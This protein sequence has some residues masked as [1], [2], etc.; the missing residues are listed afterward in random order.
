MMGNNTIKQSHNTAET[1]ETTENRKDNDIS[2]ILNSIT[3]EFL[4]GVCKGRK[5]AVVEGHGHWSDGS[6]G[7]HMPTGRN[8]AAGQQRHHAQEHL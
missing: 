1:A 8:S 6:L 3:M 4:R 2:F 7:I 5:H